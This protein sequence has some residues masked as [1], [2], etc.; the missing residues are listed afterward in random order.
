[1]ITAVTSRSASVRHHRAVIPSQACIAAA[2][3]PAIGSAGPRQ[4]K[5]FAQT[6]GSATR[7]GARTGCGAR[8]RM[9]AFDQPWRSFQPL[10]LVQNEYP[11]PRRITADP[12]FCSS[13]LSEFLAFMVRRPFGS[14]SLLLQVIEEATI[15]SGQRVT[16]G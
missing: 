15:S 7:R 3:E 4:A 12:A 5:T 13:A 6:L 16:H 8:A 10:S 1:M 11:R 9:A 14:S 2:S